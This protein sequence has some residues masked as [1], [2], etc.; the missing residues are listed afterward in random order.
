MAPLRREFQAEGQTSSGSHL[1]TSCRVCS[2]GKT[3]R[4]EVRRR[5]DRTERKTGVP[6][7]LQLRVLQWLWEGPSCPA[8]PLPGYVPFP[9]VPPLSPASSALT[10]SPAAAC[11]KALSSGLT[12]TSALHI[13]LWGPGLLKPA[14][15][16][17]SQTRPLPTIQ[18]VSS[19]VWILPPSVQGRVELQTQEV[20]W[21]SLEPLPDT[22][23]GRELE[24]NLEVLPSGSWFPQSFVCVWVPDPAP[25]FL[26]PVLPHASSQLAL[27]LFLF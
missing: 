9:E 12:P 21:V 4:W 27:S 24:E 10:F 5:K 22:E 14:T 19:R 3:G 1:R 16:H 17:C 23:P 6:S 18:Q 2:A 25:S 15:H 26:A 20:E 8:T 7:D 11:L 13:C